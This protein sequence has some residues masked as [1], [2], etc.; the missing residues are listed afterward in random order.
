M[1]NLI[2]NDGPMGMTGTGL[3]LTKK[4]SGDDVK[5]IQEKMEIERLAIAAEEMEAN[6]GWKNSANKKVA[7]TGFTVIFTKYDKNPYRTYKK[8][9]SGIILDTGIDG[10]EFYRSE[11]TGEMER[12]EAGVICCHVISVGPECKY[13]KE[14][15]DIYI[16]HV[17]SAPV[18]F[19]GK[20]YWAISEQ[21]VICRVVNND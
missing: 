18:P 20:G 1:S 21:N 6:K 15:D 5:D 11:E 12:S 8:S 2:L 9:T 7:A 17:G 19:A 3:E 13:V 14:G 10:H 16:R 4:L